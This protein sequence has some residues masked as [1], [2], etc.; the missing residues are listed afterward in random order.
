[1]R[2]HRFANGGLETNDMKTKHQGVCLATQD[3]RNGLKRPELGTG[4][5]KSVSYHRCISHMQLIIRTLV[6]AAPQGIAT[7]V[8]RIRSL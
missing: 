5:N 8:T 3:I 4:Y 1:M 2:L 6:R 7:C